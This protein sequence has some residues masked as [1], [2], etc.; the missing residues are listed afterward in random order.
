MAPQRMT[1]EEI[2]QL[3]LE[4]E[5]CPLN[6]TTQ[7]L[8][9]AWQHIHRLVT[10]VR[11][12]RAELGAHARELRLGV[13][14]LAD[15]TDATNVLGAL[16]TKR[17]TAAEAERDELR[18]IVDGRTEAPTDEEIAAHCAQGGRWRSATHA[19]TVCFGGA[20]YRVP[21]R[22]HE[23]STLPGAQSDRDLHALDDIV[24]RWWPLDSE[25]RPCAWPVVPTRSTP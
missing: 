1:D 4:C 20:T 15:V 7:P 3:A 5:A 12:A 9:V 24:A 13:A 11:R 18:A 14:V 2:E 17:A 19:H 22:S 8:D 21:A 16:L 23:A 6:A 10:E 25:G